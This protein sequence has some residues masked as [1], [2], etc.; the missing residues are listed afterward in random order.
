MPVICSCLAF[1]LDP[2][3]LRGGVHAPAVSHPPTVRLGWW[4][5]RPFLG[6]T[7][8]PLVSQCAGWVSVPLVLLLFSFGLL[9]T[10]AGPSWLSLAWCRRCYLGWFSCVACG[11]A[12]SSLPSP[13]AAS[14]TAGWATRLRFRH[15][16]LWAWPRARPTT[17]N[18]DASILPFAAGA[19]R[20][21]PTRPLPIARRLRAPSIRV[22]CAPSRARLLPRVDAPAAVQCRAVSSPHSCASCRVSRLLLAHLAVSFH[23]GRRHRAMRCG[24]TSAR[25]ADGATSAVRATCVWTR[26]VAG[27]GST[28]DV[29][30]ARAARFRS[31]LFVVARWQRHKHTK[32]AMDV[33]HGRGTGGGRCTGVRTRLGVRRSTDGREPRRTHPTWDAKRRRA[34]RALHV[35]MG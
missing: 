3:L 11:F 22:R 4:E 6:S 34:R 30:E 23:L 5:R 2:I 26:R 12:S 28:W 16:R 17:A 27:D 14:W 25:S 15:A 18:V 7:C 32:H 20:T 21:V 19:L 35:P 8:D 24:A 9:P 29:Q 13:A 10:L 31:L 1:G 33:R